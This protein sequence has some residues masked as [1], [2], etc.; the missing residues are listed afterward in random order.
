M[1]SFMKSLFMIVLVGAVAAQATL[2]AF[3]AQATITGNTFSTGTADL[4]V[5]SGDEVFV[6]SFEGGSFS[7]I[8][9]GWTQ[10]FNA[11]VLNNG[12]LDLV[13]DLTGVLVPGSDT[14]GL[15]HAL[16]VEVFEEDGTTSLGSPRTLNE[17]R[18]S[19]FVLG[20]LEAGDLKT[21]VLR[22]TAPSDL[23]P[24]YEGHSVQ[25]DFVFNGTTDGAIQAPDE[26]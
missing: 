14:D 18:T 19:P 20:E 15:R 17:W 26:P 10:D 21:V 5:D 12:S 13:V 24:Q 4:L 7:D 9:P 1:K 11:T 6:Q 2:A 16:L 25:F 3:T 8:Y 22:F 23:G